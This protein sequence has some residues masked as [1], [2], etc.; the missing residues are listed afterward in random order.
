L[1]SI[2][3]PILTSSTHTCFV[4]VAAVRSGVSV[5]LIGPLAT[6]YII[7]ARGWPF[8]LT[9]WGILNFLLIQGMR[10]D[11]NIF[12]SHWLYFTDIEMFTAENPSGSVVE[13]DIY[14]EILVAF[15]VVG[16]AT[17]LKRT[18]LALYL[19]KRL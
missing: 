1:I 7:N 8:T 15:V 16:V 2:V 9:I 19:S 17:S 4:D 6:L 12:W 11:E 5:Q 18:V 13:S 14:R 3:Q 10:D